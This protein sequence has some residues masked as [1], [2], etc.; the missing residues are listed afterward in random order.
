MKSK[1]KY[2][3]PITI[4]FSN[5]VARVHIPILEPKE[6]EKRMQN[7]HKASAKILEGEKQ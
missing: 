2:K 1:D 3:D 7:I 5:L 4:T 6:R